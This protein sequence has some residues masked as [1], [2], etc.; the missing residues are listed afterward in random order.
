MTWTVE[1]DDVEKSGIPREIRLPFIVTRQNK[2]R[3]LARVTI[4]AHYG[5]WRG[6]LARNVPVVGKNDHPLYFDPS[7][8]EEMEKSKK[9]GP[10]GKLVAEACGIF[11]DLELERW[12]TLREGAIGRR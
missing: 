7:T 3:F 1:Q 12:S 11:D 10:D 2:G 4:K 8:L 5:F 9:K 6:A